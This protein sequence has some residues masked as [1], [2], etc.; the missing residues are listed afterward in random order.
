MM[1]NKNIT[2]R[3]I[4]TG[5]RWISLSLAISFYLS[6]IVTSFAAAI[7][8]RGGVALSTA[9]NG[10]AVVEIEGPN[11]KGLSRNRFDTFNVDEKESYSITMPGRKRL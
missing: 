1:R 11:D 3:R 2:Y 4:K 6:G 7:T 10:A 5:K 9:S 8:P